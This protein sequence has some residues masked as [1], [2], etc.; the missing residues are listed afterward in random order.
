MLR[1]L[2]VGHWAGI[3]CMLSLIWVCAGAPGDAKAQSETPEVKEVWVWRAQSDQW[4]DYSDSM[5]D[6]L[7]SQGYNSPVTYTKASSPSC[8]GHFCQFQEML[9]AGANFWIDS[10]G[11]NVIESYDNVEDRNTRETQL[12]IAKPDWWTNNYLYTSQTGTGTETNPYRYVICITTLG[13]AAWCANEKQ[14]IFLGGCATANFFTSYEGGLILGYWGDGGHTGHADYGP[15][16]DLLFERMSGAQASGTMRCSQ[17]ALTGATIN[18]GQ[19]AGSDSGGGF[20]P[21]FRAWGDLVNN[22]VLAPAVKDYF[23]KSCACVANCAGWV[24]FDCTMATN[25]TNVVWDT[26]CVEI[27]NDSVT[28]VNDHK[29]EFDISDAT[30]GSMGTLRLP[31]INLRSANNEVKLD[32]NKV[33][34]N[35]DDFPWSVSCTVG[36]C[37][38][39]FIQPDQ[40]QPDE[41]MRL[42]RQRSLRQSAPGVSTE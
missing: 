13:A 4:T 6:Q 20:G 38:P 1:K 33:A 30:V 5:T 34:P 7:E 10:H 36:A 25:S 29:I 11:G 15:D 42:R 23:P 19:E 28:W 16:A 17:L 39:A 22:M 41:I 8:N 26:G 24:E 21:N 32:G 35:E 37:D 18:N 14:I 9:V 12:K 40:R 27:D 31:A 3:S 2:A